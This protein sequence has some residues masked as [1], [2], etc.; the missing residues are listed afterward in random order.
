M[1][2]VHLREAH[3]IYGIVQ[4]AGL[5]V[6][7]LGEGVTQHFTAAGWSLIMFVVSS[8]PEKLTGVI[9]NDKTMFKCQWVECGLE[10]NKESI[11]RHVTEAHLSYSYVPWHL[12]QGKYCPC[13]WAVLDNVCGV[14]VPGESL[15]VHPREAHVIGI[16]QV[17]GVPPHKLYNRCGW[18]A[19]DNV[20]GVPVP[21]ASF[22]VHLRED[23]VIGIVQF[24]G[25]PPNK[26]YYRCGWVALDNVCGVP[27]PG[28]SFKTVPPM[29]PRTSDMNASV[30]VQY[31]RPGAILL[32]QARRQGALLAVGQS[33]PRRQTW[34][35][36]ASQ[37][38][39]QTERYNSDHRRSYFVEF[40]LRGRGPL[41]RQQRKPRGKL[42]NTRMLPGIRQEAEERLQRGI[43]P[44]VIRTLDE[45]ASAKTRVQY[46]QGR[47]HF[48]VAGVTGSG[49]SSSIN[50]IRGVENRHQH[51]AE[52]GVVET[53]VTNGQYPDPNPD[54]PF[55]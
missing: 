17:A 23:R 54:L 39:A 28:P 55:V 36:L 25:L 26:M 11:G 40:L 34:R 19:L 41:Q 16:V 33:I 4:V 10:M 47:L 50:A 37:C 14:L 22:S 51:A 3:F 6:D 18:A 48:A 24:A 44:V 15:S 2:S 9:G 13:G 8:S 7:C 29:G 20:C 12:L 52:T 49:K 30:P 27:V 46:E 21:G 42:L 5:P 1:F 35:P 31:G 38:A 45:I 53:T 32:Y 43:Q